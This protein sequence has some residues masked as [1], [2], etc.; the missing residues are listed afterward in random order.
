MPRVEFT[1]VLK[2][3]VS[4]PPGTIMIAADADSVAAAL[5]VVFAE[6]PTLRGYVLD[7]QGALRRHVQIFVDGELVRDRQALSDPVK[8]DGAILV[9]QA[10][11]GGLGAGDEDHQRERDDR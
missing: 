3:H 9:M 4:C 7:D 5:E 10:L 2:R 1:P 11:S 6:N 8:P